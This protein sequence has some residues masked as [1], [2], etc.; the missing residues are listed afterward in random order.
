MISIKEILITPGHF[1]EEK[2]R[3]EAS[4]KVPVLI[5]LIAGVISGISAYIVSG[6]TIEAMGSGLEGFAFIASLFGF[7]GALIG[8]FIYWIIWV[9]AFLVMIYILKGKATFKQLAEVTGY[10][11][12][13]QI[14]GGIIT[15]AIT[16]T[17]IQNLVIPA[18]SNMHE[19]EAAMKAFT[20]SSPMMAASLVSIIFT[21]WSANIWLFGIKESSGLEFKKAAICVGVPL[22]AFIILSLSSFVM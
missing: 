18:T 12:I 6:K 7:A 1:F 15:T 13:P 8:T 10:G 5:V 17:S 11:F 21:I 16:I 22:V 3:E 4:L 14:F 20:T 2:C 9:I 19:I